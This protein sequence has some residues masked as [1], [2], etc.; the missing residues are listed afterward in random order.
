MSSPP[1]PFLLKKLRGNPGKRPMKR[2]PEPPPLER[3]PEAPSYLPELAREEWIRI[4]PELWAIGLLTVLD[5]APLS[6]Y[7]CSYALWRQ[8]SE[9]LDSLLVES[10]NGGPRRH[11]LLKVIA[12]AARD[13]VS[14]SGLFGMSPVAR[15]RIAAGIHHQP[16]SKFAGLL[17]EDQ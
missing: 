8:A 4:A 17:G 13:M 1:V 10:Q 5:I 15:E 3:C 11:P 6:A 14:Y 9:E 16:P 12:D 2:G 7:C